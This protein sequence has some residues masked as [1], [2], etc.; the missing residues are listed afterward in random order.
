MPA[1]YVS[2]KRNDMVLELG[3]MWVLGLRE[4]WGTEDMKPGGSAVAAF[5]GG[6]WLPA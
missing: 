5:A 6:E 4:Q 1:A 2:A 3:A